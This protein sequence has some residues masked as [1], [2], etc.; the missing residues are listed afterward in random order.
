[1]L[2]AAIAA[3]GCATARAQS[4]RVSPQSASS[5]SD[6]ALMAA[7]VRQLPLGSRVRVSLA[8]G[9]VIRGTLMKADEDPIVVQRRTRIPETPLRIAIK[10]VQG[11]ELEGKGTGVGRV[12]AVGI[13]SG[14][15]AALGFM[16]IIAAL[17]SD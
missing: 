5:A 12:V 11:L 16:M 9:Q 17:L 15:G 3:S 7:Y 2:A 13:A 1:M 4:A 10:D 6:P 8:D 14:V